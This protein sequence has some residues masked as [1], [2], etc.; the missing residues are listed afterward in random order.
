[1]KWLDA[2]IDGMRRGTARM[3]V[4]PAVGPFSRGGS[5]VNVI[6]CSAITLFGMWF[7]L[8]ETTFAVFFVLIG[9][10]LTAVFVRIHIRARRGDFD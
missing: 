1:M 4:M 6:M 3:N 7:A 10:A 9:L 8:T 2:Y 5:L